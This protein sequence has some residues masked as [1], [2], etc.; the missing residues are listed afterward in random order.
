MLIFLTQ[1]KERGRDNWRKNKNKPT[2][3]AKG[4]GVEHKRKEEGV[5]RKQ[6]MNEKRKGHGCIDMKEIRE[7]D[8]SMVALVETSITKPKPNHL[9]TLALC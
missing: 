2:N 8:G 9:V 5:M 4:E 1:E 6:G 3:W 7:A